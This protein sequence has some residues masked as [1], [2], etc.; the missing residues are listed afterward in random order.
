MVNKRTFALVPLMI[1]STM[2]WISASNCSSMKPEN[3][4]IVGQLFDDLEAYEMGCEYGNG[5][6]CTYAGW[7]NRKNPSMKFLTD[8]EVEYFKR[9]CDLNQAISCYNY[10]CFLARNRNKDE[11]AIIIEKSFI[12][13]FNRWGIIE[14][15]PD[16]DSLRKM[17]NFQIIMFKYK[18]L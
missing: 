7:R 1:F 10:A 14:E 2:D 16:L 13:G 6:S 3:C 11:A 4:F 12:L 5:P 8:R 15:D 9:G 17:K 18:N